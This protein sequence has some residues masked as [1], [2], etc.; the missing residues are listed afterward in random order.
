M[1]K[2]FLAAML[3]VTSIACAAPEPQ[4]GGVLVF[5]RSGDSTTMDPSHATDGESFYAASAIYDNLV[6]FK[7]GT[8]EIEPALAESWR[9]V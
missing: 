2:L 1:K 6:Q 7:Y 3:L 5:G 8:T 9:V 4:Y